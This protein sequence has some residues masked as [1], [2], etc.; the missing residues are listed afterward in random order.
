MRSP[1]HHARLEKRVIDRSLD[2]LART[3]LFKRA[4]RGL[5]RTKTYHGIDFVRLSSLAL[6]DQMFAHAIKVLHPREQ[7]GLWYLVKRYPL[8]TSRICAEQSILLGHVRGIAK[9]LMVVRNKTLFHLD[10][11]GV[12]DPSA[13]W[14]KASITGRQFDDAVDAAFRLLCHLRKHIK[15]SAYELPEYDDRDV[16]RILQLADHADLF[17]HPLS[18]DPTITYL[19]EHGFWLLTSDGER[20]LS[21]ANFPWFR[22]APVSH[23]LKVEQPSPGH[24]RWPDLDIDLSLS[25]IR[26]PDRFPLIARAS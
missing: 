25:I 22:D 26:N 12:L 11:D 19:S 15:G 24:F 14:K 10:A 18:D 5:H 8:E 13:V 17:S 23:I 4:L 1:S 2:E 20:F 3:I 16:T 21:F 6:Y 9:G 7:A